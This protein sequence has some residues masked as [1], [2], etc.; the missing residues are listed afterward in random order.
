MT[1][2]DTDPSWTTLQSS[3]HL[4]TVAWER[5]FVQTAEQDSHFGKEACLAVLTPNQTDTLCMNIL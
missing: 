3:V 2:P 5:H 4:S 1:L